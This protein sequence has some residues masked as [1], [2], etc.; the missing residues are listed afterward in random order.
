MRSGNIETYSSAAR[1][2]HW[3]TV[4][5]IAIQFPVGVAMA[6]RGDWLNIWDAL[7]NN[8]YSLHK[9]L[10]CVVFFVVAARLAYRLTHGVPPDEPTLEPWQKT[11]SG[12]THW[13]IYALLLALPVVGWFGIQLYPALDVFGLFNLPAI[14][15]PDQNAAG[16]MLGLHKILALLLLVCLGMH[17]GAA[18]FHYLIRRDGVLNRMIP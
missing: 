5:L 9:L 14:V 2:F 13:A 11:L 7:T 3:W 16:V 18:L 12:I 8:M 6:V 4:A 15:S 1:H 10:G 17:V